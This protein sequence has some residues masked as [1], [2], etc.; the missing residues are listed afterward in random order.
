MG[1]MM[2]LILWCKWMK[3]CIGSTTTSVLVND[4]HTD[5]FP[6][7]NLFLVIELVG[8]SIWLLLIFSLLIIL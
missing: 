2:F 5:E 7:N 1:K 8:T 4:S 6:L 3:E